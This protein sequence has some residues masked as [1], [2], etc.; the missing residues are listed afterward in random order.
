MGLTDLELNSGSF[1]G[2][3]ASSFL[4]YHVRK[5]KETAIPFELQSPDKWSRLHQLVSTVQNLARK[6]KLHY[7]RSS[8]GAKYS[9]THY[10]LFFFGFFR[11]V[12][13][14]G[15]IPE[16]TPKGQKEMWSR[17]TVTKKNK[18]W[19]EKHPE[20]SLSK[21]RVVFTF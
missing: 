1:P 19:L 5:W 12:V 20:G 15:L 17:V 11:I 14:T 8:E 4:I 10:Y 3:I 16:R 7:W 9:K 2:R 13:K 6:L 18:K 21:D